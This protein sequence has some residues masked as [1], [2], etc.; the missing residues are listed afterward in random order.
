[1]FKL[2]A[3]DLDGTLLNSQRKISKEALDILSRTAE[4]GIDFVICTGR[5]YDSLKFIL[6]QLPFC[7][8]AITCMG[9]EIYDNFQKKRIYA[10]T[11]DRNDVLWV[12]DYALKRNIHMNIYSDNVLYTN[13]LDEYSQIYFK[14]TTTMAQAIDGDVKEFLKSRDLTKLVLIDEPDKIKEYEKDIRNHF[15]CNL[16]ICASSE[17]FVEMSSIKAQK[18]VTLNMLA[19]K[20]SVKKNEM[21]VFG[22][23]GNDVAMLKNTGFSVCVANGWDEAKEVSDIIVESNDNDGVARTVNRLIL[24]RLEEK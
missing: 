10:E 21:I 17:Y 9:A 22:D 24:S 14:E 1:M 6:P 2:I 15:G 13:S 18:D 7:K 3:S 4:K 12:A 11:M 19:D 8:Y 16:N 20:L 5:M 23:S